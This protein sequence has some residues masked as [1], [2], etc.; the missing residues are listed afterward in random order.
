MRSIKPLTASLAMLAFAS[1]ASGCGGPGRIQAA[2]PPVQDLAVE[3]KPVPGEDVLTSSVAEAEFN[4]K[5]ESWGERG[6]S[7]VGRICRW[8]KAHGGDVD[9][10]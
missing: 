10:P 6:W 9:C 5:L 3:A 7:A 1:I 4:S 2:L 8:A